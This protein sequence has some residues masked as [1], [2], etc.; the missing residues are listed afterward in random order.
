VD[1]TASPPPCSR[2]KNMSITAFHGAKLE[3]L[4]WMLGFAD[5]WEEE[6][7]SFAWRAEEETSTHRQVQRRKPFWHCEFEDVRV[8]IHREARE[9]WKRDP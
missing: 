8:V 4:R 6:D 9:K 7:E 1:L 2:P 3:L 5:N